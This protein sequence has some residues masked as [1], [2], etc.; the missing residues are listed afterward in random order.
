M[1][2]TFQR[3]RQPEQKEQRRAHL[4]STAREQLAGGVGLR[5][6][7]LNE[8]A[9]QARMAKANVYRYFDTR[10]ALLLALLWEAWQRW[11]DGL[12][13]AWSTLETPKR[14]PRPIALESVAAL[15]A[16]TLANE[17]LL[18]ELTA[19]LPTVLEQN[20]GEDAI[21]GFKR[22]SLAFFATIA[23]FLAERAPALSEA[24]YAEL[25]HDGA[26]A[27][28]GL[29]P[30]LH[31]TPAAAR[32]LEDPSLRFFRRDFGAELDRVLV[33]LAL[34]HARREAAGAVKRA[35]RPRTGG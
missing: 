33:A 11:F 13:D 34:D 4:L 31:P 5:A 22:D 19:A 9:R 10:E 30:A 8:I 12:R 17:P 20:L 26:H 16:R 32:A 15:L 24:A 28:M 7:S 1:A 21:R 27:I 29:H 3:A 35:S 23:R 18:C 25:L 2:S 14:K 6:L